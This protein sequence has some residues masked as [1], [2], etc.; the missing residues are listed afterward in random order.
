MWNG[1]FTILFK[2]LSERV[3]GFDS[4]SKMFYTLIYG[5]FKGI[6]LDF[7]SVIWAQFV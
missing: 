3:K 4:A 5:L 6:T 2:G 7:G 1:L